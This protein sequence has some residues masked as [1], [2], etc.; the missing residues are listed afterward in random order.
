M[1]QG[2]G[3]CAMLACIAAMALTAGP[4]S[5]AGAVDGGPGTPP[6]AAAAAATVDERCNYDSPVLARPDRR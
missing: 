3:R 4:T 5:A 6:A 2:L 1:R